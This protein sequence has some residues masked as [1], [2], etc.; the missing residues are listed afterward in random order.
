MGLGFGVSE[1]HV[2]PRPRLASVAL[3]HV[4]TLA[5]MASPQLA[6]MV[7]AS[8]LRAASDATAGLQEARGVRGDESA[9]GVEYM[10]PARNLV[11]RGGLAAVRVQRANPRVI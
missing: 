1:D 10:V 8:E 11:A 4:T 3:W 6:E 5:C 9:I 2:L 7:G